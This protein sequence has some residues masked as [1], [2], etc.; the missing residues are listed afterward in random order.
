MTPQYEQND[1]RCPVCG[2]E[3]LL[4]ITMKL[5][6]KGCPNCATSLQPLKIKDDGYV[7]VNWQDLRT[8]AIYAERWSSMFDMSVKGNQD[9]VR[10]L[11]NIL[12]HLRTYQ[13]KEA[14]P[15]TLPVTPIVVIQKEK[16]TEN[17][18]NYPKTPKI[19]IELDDSKRELKPDSTGNIPSPF[20]QKK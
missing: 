11:Q 12:T 16:E 13:P 5:G 4:S 3:W 20:Y 14:L 19:R 17:H 10:A 6:V 1:M 18:G 7:K 9:A 15:L 8:I 2:K